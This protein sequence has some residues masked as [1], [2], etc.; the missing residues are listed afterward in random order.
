M[1]NLYT[2]SLFLIVG[3]QVLQAATISITTNK[4]WSTITTGTGVSGQPSSSDLII[5][6]NGA[7]LT[8][9]VAS[10]VC[11]SIQLAS[12]NAA[13]TLTI[14]SN[15]NLTLDTIY[16]G[17]LTK[18]GTLNMT[19]TA[20]VLNIKSFSQTGNVNT[21]K[22]NATNGS[23]NLLQ[24]NT[25]PSSTLFINFFKLNIL[26][27]TTTLT[28]ATTVSSTLNVAANATLNLAST[29]ITVS[30]STVIDGN[31]NDDA[32]VSTATFTNLTLNQGATITTLSNTKCVVSGSLTL[33]GFTSTNG[34]GAIVWTVASSL[35]I[36][37]GTTNTL[38][39]NSLSV[40]GSSNISGTINWHTFNINPTF[41]AVNI[42]SGGLWTS[43]AIAPLTFTCNGLFSFNGGQIDGLTT[44]LYKLNVGIAV[45]NGSIAN[46]KKADITVQTVGSTINGT[47]SFDDISGNISFLSDLTISSTGAFTTTVTRS[48]NF[49][50]NL[51][52]NG[53]FTAGNGTYTFIGNKS[54]SSTT[55][56]YTFFDV[57]IS[58][59]TRINNTTV[60]INNSLT[61]AGTFRQAVGSVLNIQ[62]S[63]NLTGFIANTAINTVNYNPSSN[64]NLQKGFYYHLNLNSNVI[65]NLNA[66]TTISGDFRI[67]AGIVN[68]NANI[69]GN[70][71]GV[72]LLN[73]SAEL[74]IGN[75]AVATAISF[76]FNFTTANINL[77]T[78]SIVRYKSNIAQT[79]SSLP[80]YSNL[81]ICTGISSVTKII[82]SSF[83]NVFG[84]LTIKNGVILSGATKTIRVVNNFLG[85]GVLTF[86]TGT[87]TF[88]LEGVWGFTG[89]FICGKSTT[90]FNS[91]S[92][93]II[94]ALT[95]YNLKSTFKEGD[96][97]LSSTGVINILNTLTPDTNNYIVTGSTINYNGTTAQ[98]SP[99]FTYNNLTI[100]NSLGLSLA[101]DIGIKGTL[102][103]ALGK[104]TTTGKV[105]TLLS[106]ATQ[107]GRIDPVITG[108]SI[109][110]NITQQR[111]TP[112]TSAGWGYL[113]SPV[114]NT[115]LAD[116][117]NNGLEI[118]MTG[119]TGVGSVSPGNFISVYTYDETAPGAFGDAAAYVAP[120][121]VTN[122]I[123][124]GKGY[125]VY[126]GSSLTNSNP[127]TFD[128]TG[129]PKTGNVTLPIS[130]TNNGLSNDD[131]WNLVANPYP[132]DIDW[133]SS[134]WAK[135]NINSTIYIFNAN[136]NN[137]ATFTDGTTPDSTN[138]GSRYIA[139]S[140]GF[141]VKATSPF[142]VLSC[143]ENVKTANKAPFFKSIIDREDEI[144]MKITKSGTP[145]SDEAT[146]RFSE[147]ASDFFE[148]N[149]D[150]EKLYPSFG[151]SVNISTI[152]DN[153]KLTT[154]V[155][156]TFNQSFQLPF[157]IDVSEQGN[158]QIAF[159]GINKIKAKYPEFFEDN[160]FVIENLTTGKTVDLRENN[161]YEFNGDYT[162]MK[163]VLRFKTNEATTKIEKV[164][165]FDI[166][167]I[168]AFENNFFAEFNIS[169]NTLAK[170]DLYNLSGQIIK[171]STVVS[172]NIKLVQIDTKNLETGIYILNIMAG[173]KMINR[174]IYIQN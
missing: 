99:A 48:F 55:G 42:N 14:S 117:Y 152:A 30:G 92:S 43:T 11:K 97:V 139:S 115:T 169:E 32:V 114:T 148:S 64:I 158:Y 163:L 151:E 90:S 38:G 154:N 116:W 157:S 5:V 133:T 113:G 22:L 100:T 59:G 36:T 112:L 34:V 130:Y 74:N 96:R 110:G 70:A 170:I 49:S 167:N 105:L 98:V 62:N 26:S 63:I 45:T 136:T 20:S 147:N 129:L 135:T 160:N 65:Y 82:G 6:R 140:Q 138:G 155:L 159:S 134:A 106:D 123:I 24:T 56:G 85:D 78:G 67:N 46:I 3:I 127:F 33:S 40:G 156:K 171:P 15:V 109:I 131:G 80:N 88:N 164:E 50:G 126:M 35:N 41:K 17:D 75:D 12:L 72:L 144:R 18:I 145:L 66:A 79:I 142:C 51:N 77:Q 68:L 120:T 143:T 76:P 122:S 25:L 23:I 83:L 10:S 9:D 28:N 60:T 119:F 37:S 87:G 141:F 57:V 91:R 149:L 111:Y 118:P 1:R 53:S 54:I 84:N 71:T 7:T 29:N 102:K 21:A 73:G 103:I 108:T 39:G 16:M 94:P 47:I 93:Q 107:T 95:Y 153:K 81:E 128:A 13:G 124:N 52:N 104:I 161:I 8:V 69:T 132:S 174:K 137:Y 44:N 165:L 166:I 168:K 4:L 19:T 121:N 31:I 2:L 172:T 58:S 150:I 146:V 89:T 162:S 173:N 125:F 86:G 101:G 61:G 27:G